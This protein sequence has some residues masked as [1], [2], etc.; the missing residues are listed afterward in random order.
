MEIN[1]RLLTGLKF[2]KNRAGPRFFSSDIITAHFYKSGN[3]LDWRS[4]KFTISVMVGKTSSKSLTILLDMGSGKQ[5]VF[6]TDM[7]I[8][9]AFITDVHEKCERP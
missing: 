7:T 3:T 9:L 6:D 2:G 5:E 8:F 4:K 1:G